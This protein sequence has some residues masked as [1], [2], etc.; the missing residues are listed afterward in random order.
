M[1]SPSTAASASA[2]SFKVHLAIYDLSH[3]MAR[4]LSAQFLGGPQYAIDVIP[5]SGIIVYGQ[6]YFFGA[7]IQSESPALFRQM[8]GMMPIQ[9]LSLGR[10]TVTRT[11]FEQWCQQQQRFTMQSYDLLQCNCNHFAHAAAVEGLRLP[12]GVPDWVLQVPQRFLASP[13]GQL[14]RP[15]LDQMQLRA[16]VQGAHAMQTSVP[17]AAANLWATNSESNPWA[18]NQQTSNSSTGVGVNAAAAANNPRVNTVSSNS[19]NAKKKSNNTD[20]SSS[21]SSA[22]TS[23]K[24]PPHPLLDSF[25]KPLVSKDFKTIPLCIQKIIK[26]VSDL[27]PDDKEF[28]QKC[29]ETMVSTSKGLVV[30]SLE[31]ATRLCTLLLQCLERQQQAVMTHAIMLLRILVAEERYATACEQCLHWIQQHVIVDP[32]SSSTD[33]TNNA[34]SVPSLT[35]AWLVL[36]NA[37]AAAVTAGTTTTTMQARFWSTQEEEETWVQAAIRAMTNEAASSVRQ[38]AAACCYN[39]TLLLPVRESNDDEVDNNT[40][41][42]TQVSMLCAALED[43][44]SETDATVQLRRLMMAGRILLPLNGHGSD[45]ASTNSAIELARNLGLQ[46]SLQPLLS[47]S[48][49]TT[50]DADTSRRLALELHGLLHSDLS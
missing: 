37:I 34:L 20:S 21:T 16:P 31:D 38:A 26:T 42:D 49:P 28:L 36:S 30:I 11:M 23:S 9:T 2:E 17:N 24:R 12:Q 32:S 1:N 46:E 8:T 7:G 4:Q 18:N 13:M 22:R 44:A 25:V 33:S 19:D 43:L 40:L 14:V 39:M 15:M 6:E 48:K 27:Q 5:H 50:G 45:D 41:S 29:Q 47:D 3:G 35:M 10:T